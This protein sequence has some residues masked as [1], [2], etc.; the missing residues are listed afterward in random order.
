ML[1]GFSLSKVLHAVPPRLLE[2]L[3]FKLGHALPDV[4]WM[5]IERGDDA[6]LVA[7]LK[8]L[9]PEMQDEIES[10]LAAIF[11]L[12]CPMGWQALVQASRQAGTSAYAKQRALSGNLFERALQIWLANETLFDLA[13]L[14]H[15]VGINAGWPRPRQAKPHKRASRAALIE[16]LAKHLKDHIASAQEHLR[17]TTERDG[18]TELLPRPSQRFL[19][20][21]TRTSESAVSRCLHD[22][23]ARELR[24]LWEIAD[25]L[26]RLLALSP[27]R[28]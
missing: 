21:L 10:S 13:L 28:R 24:L 3:F 5:T 9:P 17:M 11:E 8:K 26:D 14:V 16:L 19:A 2:Q 12:A 27:P 23:A 1:P 7:A 18:L 25:D 20:R 6:R 4:D 22:P 15:R